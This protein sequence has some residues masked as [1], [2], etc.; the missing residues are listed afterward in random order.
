M[1]KRIGNDF[2][3]YWIIKENWVIVNPESVHDFKIEIKHEFSGSKISPQFD[4]VNGSA[5]V[6]CEAFE[7]LGVYQ[8][9]ATWRVTDTTFADGF[10]DCAADI[11]SFEIVGRSAKADNE[12]PEITSEMAIGFEGSDAYEVWV[13]N[14]NQGKTYEDYIAFLREPM[15]AAIHDAEV[16]ATLWAQQEAAREVAEAARQENTSIA[17]ENAELAT[18]N[19]ISA[20]DSMLSNLISLEI[21]DDLCLWFETPET[22]SGITFEVQNGNLIATI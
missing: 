19:A 5:R 13:K 6:R 21:R 11:E 7:K 17:I 22:Y 10:R 4:I 9:I 18:E 14:G 3:F 1:K 15:T 12:N 2:L 20:T 8:L 16:L